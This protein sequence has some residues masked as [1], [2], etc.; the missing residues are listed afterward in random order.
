MEKE[1]KII[2]MLGEGGFGIVYLVEKDNKRYALK[3]STKILTKEEIEQIK[4]LINVLSKINNEYLIK[5]YNIFME[6]DTFY[7]LMEFAGEK[8]L[9]QFINKYNKKVNIL[10]KR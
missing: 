7:I 6:N 10:M 1:Y 2:K 8:N 4:K 9:K 5:Y 3:K